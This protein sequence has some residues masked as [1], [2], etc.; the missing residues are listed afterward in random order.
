MSCA[1]LERAELL[2]PNAGLK[3]IIGVHIVKVNCLSCYRCWGTVDINP[4]N[5]GR[6][7]EKHAI[8]PR[9]FVGDVKQR[10]FVT[11]TVTLHPEVEKLLLACNQSVRHW[12]SAVQN[13]LSIHFF[14]RLLPHTPPQNIKTLPH[15]FHRRGQFPITPFFRKYPLGHARAK[16]FNTTN[17][18][19][20]HVAGH[21]KKKCG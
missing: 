8:A 12:C 6:Y 11:F 20:R 18:V 21:T 15:V 14:A 1:A 7:Q 2:R 13:H 9:Q 5:V 19:R 16:R 4:V 10:V 3:C 17:Y